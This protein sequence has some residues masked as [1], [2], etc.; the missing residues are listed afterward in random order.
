MSRSQLLP[1]VAGLFSA[2][3][4]GVFSPAVEGVFPGDDVGA[5]LPHEQL[6]AIVEGFDGR[7][8]GVALL[9]DVQRVP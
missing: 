3:G 7:R 5:V 9:D 8:A 4:A 2:A 6:D 1:A